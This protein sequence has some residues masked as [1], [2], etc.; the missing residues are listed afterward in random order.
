MEHL[1]FYL[2][3]VECYINDGYDLVEVLVATEKGSDGEARRKVAQMMPDLDIVD[4]NNVDGRWQV[5]RLTD[6]GWEFYDDMNGVMILEEDMY[7]PKYG[8]TADDFV[9]DGFYDP[10]NDDALSY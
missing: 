10:G 4:V 6:L 5:T 7:N 3:T 9:Y 2:K 8:F 1:D